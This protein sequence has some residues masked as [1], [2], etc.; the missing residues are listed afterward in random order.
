MRALIAIYQSFSPLIAHVIYAVGF[1][2]PQCR[3]EPT[4][5]EYA[6]GAIEKYGILQGSYKSV[7]RILR[8]NMF[9][10]GGVD[11]P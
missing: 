8:C 11:L 3:F 9:H 2:S 6:H 4:C 5:S 1:I 7:H 10:A